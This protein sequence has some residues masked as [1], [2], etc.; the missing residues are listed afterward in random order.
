MRPLRTGRRR[1]E[2]HFPPLETQVFCKTR[3]VN[4]W[5]VDGRDL[6]GLK[7]DLQLEMG[8][9]SASKLIEAPVVGNVCRLGQDQLSHT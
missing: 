9:T 3:P 6:G 8:L 2:K 1:V 7:S 5:M 4:C